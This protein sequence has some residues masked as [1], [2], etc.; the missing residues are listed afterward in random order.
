MKIII[1]RLRSLVVHI[2]NLNGIRN[3]LQHGKNVNGNEEVARLENTENK[4][5][6]HW[7]PYVQ[8]KAS[9]GSSISDHQRFI[10]TGYP[11]WMNEYD[12]LTKLENLGNRIV[13]LTLT[14]YWQNH[15]CVCLS[16]IIVMWFWWTLAFKWFE[17]FIAVFIWRTIRAID[18]MEN[19]EDTHT[20]P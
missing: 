1:F 10:D 6:K 3:R 9:N 11:Y 5:A 14:V 8:L 13:L 16:I 12:T 19:R 2:Y 7:P 18:W 15:N 17:W 4:P 20:S